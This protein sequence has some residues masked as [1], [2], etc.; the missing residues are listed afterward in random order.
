MQDCNSF[1]KCIILHQIKMHFWPSLQQKLCLRANKIGLWQT[2]TQ[3]WK[4]RT[5]SIKNWNKFYEVG[6]KVFYQKYQTKKKYWEV[7]TLIQRIGRMIYLV[8]GPKMM[9]KRHLNQT[10]SRHINEKNDTPVDVEPMEVQFDSFDVPISRCPV[11]WGCRI[12][13][14]HLCRGVRPPNECPGYDTKQ[15]DGEVPVMLGLWGMQSTPSLP[16][17]PSPLW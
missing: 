6:E 12:H 2:E 3:E 9:H 13:R 17:L 7:G 14:L 1:Y 15:S 4:S 10:K 5:Y 11:G 16:L 8:K